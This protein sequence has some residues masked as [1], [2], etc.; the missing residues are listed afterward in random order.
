MKWTK[1]GNIFNKH[2]AQVPVVDTY[3]TF[4]RIYYSTR[5]DGKSNPMF[6]D[7]DKVSFKLINESTAPILSLG[8]KGYFDWAG[9]MPTEIVN[10]G[11][12]KY[13]YYIGWSNR[14]D[15]PYHNC[16]G[17][18][19][20]TDDGNTWQKVSD[21]PV[22]NTSRN[23]PGYIGTISI[24]GENDG[25]RGWYLSCRNWEEIDG[26][27]EPI[28][29]IKYATSKDGLSWTPTNITCIPLRENEGGIS[30]A[31]VITTTD[32]YEMWFSYRGKCNYRTKS[33]QS[34]RIGYAKSTDGLTWSRQ[35]SIEL[36]I[37]DDGWDSEMVAYPHIIL[38]T[39]RLVMFYNG[40]KFGQT[41][42]GYATLTR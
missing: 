25:L 19:I 17:L 39:D 9:V 13:L 41:G 1:Q 16:L 28:Y 18:A 4:Y 14:I 38:E 26:I 31:S 7:I 36:D 29:D 12:T 23:E 42:I 11:N 6:I 30:K 35:D 5:I 3:D 32:G 20:S 21:G 34:Y 37:S 33:D 2:H 27:M 8:N 15:V 40:N 10:I 22:F 24:L